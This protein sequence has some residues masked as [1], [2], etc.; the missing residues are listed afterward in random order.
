[1]KDNGQFAI[2]EKK[3]TSNQ[4][5]TIEKEKKMKSKD[6]KES[7]ID[8]VKAA[9]LV[10]DYMLLDLIYKLLVRQMRH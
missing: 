4:E 3:H 10:A 5:R 8:M 2:L 7:I 1:M 6:L 9:E